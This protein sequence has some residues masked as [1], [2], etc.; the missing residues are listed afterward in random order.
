MVIAHEFTKK[1]YEEE[2]KFLHP[3]KLSKVDE[4]IEDLTDF[5][6]LNLRALAEREGD[7]VVPHNA[8]TDKIDELK[9]M[10]K[11]QQRRI[12]AVELWLRVACFLVFCCVICLLYIVLLLDFYLKVYFS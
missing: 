3:I 2:P 8:T 11:V 6:A 5:V 4:I 7:A 9:E 12:E 1:A 10:V